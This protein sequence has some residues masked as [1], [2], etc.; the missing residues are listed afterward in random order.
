MKH[1]LLSALQLGQLLKSA[2]K[3]MHLNQQELGARVGLS[4]ARISM[5]ER[6]PHTIGVDQLLT[7]L[8]V[9]QLELVVQDRLTTDRT[10]TPKTGEAATS[11]KP[12]KDVE[13]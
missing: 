4:Q 10:V 2:R 9:L 5:M 3:R 8:S 1:L 11:G 13:W 6:E 12:S 7:L